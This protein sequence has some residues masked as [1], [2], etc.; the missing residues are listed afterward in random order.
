MHSLRPNKMF[1]AQLHVTAALLHASKR[2]PLEGEL[3]ETQG[4]PESFGEEISLARLENRTTTSQSTS[5]YPSH[6]TD[7]ITSITEPL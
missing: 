7:C 6:F 2:Y 4:L 5:P 1:S 3:D